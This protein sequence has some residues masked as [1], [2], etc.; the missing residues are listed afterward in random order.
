MFHCNIL[1]CTAGITLYG[2]VIKDIYAV[3]NI[4][5]DNANGS[6][7]SDMHSVCKTHKSRS[8]PGGALDQRIQG[9]KQC[10]TKSVLRKMS[11]QECPTKSVLPRVSQSKSVLPKMFQHKC[12]AKIV[13][14][15]VSLPECHS[16]CVIDSVS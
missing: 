11:Y 7:C 9:K 16:K 15:R 10:P 1:W 3:G 8:V 4:F 2:G 13:L 14:P 6:C 12:I 5:S